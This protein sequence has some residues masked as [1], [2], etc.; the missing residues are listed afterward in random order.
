MNK[1]FNKTTNNQT[2]SVTALLIA[3]LTLLTALVTFTA[4][5]KTTSGVPL[6][7]S[8]IA[9]AIIA[10]GNNMALMSGNL[11]EFTDTGSIDEETVTNTLIAELKKNTI[12]SEAGLVM[13]SIPDN[14]SPVVNVDGTYNLTIDLF[15]FG[16]NV[17]NPSQVRAYAIHTDTTEQYEG[18]E[19]YP[20]DSLSVSQTNETPGMVTIKVPSQ[21]EVIILDYVRQ[22]QAET[23]IETTVANTPVPT[24]P[25]VMTTRYVIPL[26]E[27]APDETPD[28]TPDTTEAVTLSEPETKTSTMPTISNAV[29]N[30]TFPEDDTSTCENIAPVMGERA[31]YNRR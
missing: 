8:E 6:N 5:S 27:E 9:A 3:T 14:P 13:A 31:F 15:V 18:E 12:Y 20:T 28:V 7:Y 30:V 29:T 24:Y 2:Q 1:R 11:T 17:T 4:A 16:G 26:P 19:V 25:E 23:T 21:N 10:K 22:T